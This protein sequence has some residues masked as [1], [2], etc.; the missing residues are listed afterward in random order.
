MPE[1]F[2][3]DNDKQSRH[4][5]CQIIKDSKYNFLSIYESSTANLALFLLKQNNPSCMVIDLSMPDMDGIKLGPTALEKY[6]DLPVV[7]VTY[8]KMFSLVQDAI[9]A[10]FTANLMKALSKMDLVET[11]ERVLTPERVRR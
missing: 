4:E 2:L 8:L 6:P 3:V 5:F 9:S 7:V 11:F 10:G 1:V